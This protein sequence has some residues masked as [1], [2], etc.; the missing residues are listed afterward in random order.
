MRIKNAAKDPITDITSEIIGIVIDSAS[1]ERNQTTVTEIRRRCSNFEISWS[2][3][4]SLNLSNLVTE[5]KAAR[6][7]KCRIG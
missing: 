3:R 7:Q 1:A 2:V 4:E 5:R 6:P